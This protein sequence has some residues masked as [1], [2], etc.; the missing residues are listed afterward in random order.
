LNGSTGVVDATFQP[1]PSGGTKFSVAVSGTT[2]CAGGAYPEFFATTN[3][4]AIGNSWVQY[5]GTP[6]SYSTP[7]GIIVRAHPSVA[8]T[9]IGVAPSYY[10]TDGNGD[11]S[12]E[13]F[14]AWNF[15]VSGPSLNYTSSLAYGAPSYSYQTQAV[16][17]TS[18]HIYY[19]YDYASTFVYVMR[20]TIGS[21]GSQF[22][23]PYQQ[24][25]QGQPRSLWQRSTDS[26]W[27]VGMTGNQASPP[28]PTAIAGWTSALASITQYNAL[29]WS[30]F[31]IAGVALTDGSFLLGNVY[32]GGNKYL[33]KTV[34]APESGAT[35]L[36]P[37]TSAGG[38]S[39]SSTTGQSYKNQTTLR[40]QKLASGSLLVAQR[41]T[42]FFS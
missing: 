35:V 19:A 14:F 20:F 8:N 31:A 39:S 23:S 17:V 28:A 10:Y 21:A 4:S 3:G 36:A 32:N 26:S 13:N 15:T 25:Y 12:Q 11:S 42:P 24:V 40:L 7:N 37:P 18:T 1:N 27:W 41:N 5:T 6:N 22:Q 16:V 2:V 38:S 33:D 34:I 29:S 30:S 9:F